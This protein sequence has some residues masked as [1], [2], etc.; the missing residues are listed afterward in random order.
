[1]RHDSLI[2]KIAKVVNVFE[3]RLGF[4]VS[5]NLS[6]EWKCVEDNL[7]FTYDCYSGIV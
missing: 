2:D 5:T 1:M 4:W 3:N 7:S 6:E